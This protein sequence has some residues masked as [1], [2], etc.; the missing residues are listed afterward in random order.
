[1]S[2]KRAPA[3]DPTTMT[4]HEGKSQLAQISCSSVEHLPAVL[5]CAFARL[6]TPSASDTSAMPGK[7]EVAMFASIYRN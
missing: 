4:A 3:S 1:M 2:R 6:A 7:L 5:G